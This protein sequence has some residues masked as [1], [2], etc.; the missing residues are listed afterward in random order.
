[1][2]PTK[3]MGGRQGRYHWIPLNFWPSSCWPFIISMNKVGDVFIFSVWSSTHLSPILVHD[4]IF[5]DRIS[6]FSQGQNMSYTSLH[7][8]LLQM[9]LAK[10]VNKLF[11]CIRMVH[12]LYEALSGKD[13]NEHLNLRPCF[14]PCCQWGFW[15]GW[16]KRCCPSWRV[17]ACWC[18]LGRRSAR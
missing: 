10:L 12:N 11:G 17:Q 16:Q 7:L 1:M 13:E 2:T 8:W 15:S 4:F 5:M 3:H 9:I 18:H 6:R 14:S